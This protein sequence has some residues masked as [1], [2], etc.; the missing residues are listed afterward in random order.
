MIG[1]LLRRSWAWPWELWRSG[2]LGMNRRQATL[3]LRLNP[4]PLYPRVDDKSLTKTICEANG[5]PT[6]ETFLLVERFG[7]IAHFAERLGDRREF[8]VKPTRG[9]AGRGVL[10]VAD[11]GPEGYRTSGGALV[12]E[13]AM[14]YHLSSILAGQFSLGGRADRALVERRLRRHPAFEVLAVDGTPDVRVVVYRDRPIM[15][16]TRLPTRLS[17]GRANLHQ[18]AVGAGIDMATGRTTDGVWR[19]ERVTEAP[20]TGLPLAGVQVPH[21][22]EVLE[23]A[24]RLSR[25]LELGYVG[26]DIV[27]DA[28]DGPVVLEANA[29]P[30]LGIQIANRRGLLT[31]IRE[32]DERLSPRMDTGGHG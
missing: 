12:T 19:G 8:V 25:A 21:W 7:D 13:S 4:R 10:V 32:V 22:P 24:S 27:L 16:M 18:G 17:G 11:R 20:D 14:R 23:I 5:V 6:P 15:A 26:V 30:G 2:V 28:D 3:T 9:A 31:A 29:R 1:R